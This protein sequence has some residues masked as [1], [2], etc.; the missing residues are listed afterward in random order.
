MKVFFTSYEAFGEGRR[1]SDLYVPMNEL[2]SERLAGRSYGPALDGDGWF[3]M[4]IFQR[5]D[6]PRSRDPERTLY[7]RK[8]AGID[9]R[10]Q[11]DCAAWRA[12]DVDERRRLLYDVIRRTFDI[13]RLKKVPNLDVDAFERDVEAVAL[14]QGWA[15]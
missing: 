7:Q 1:S 12:A 10:L 14:E 5:E 3:L 8:A 4:F 6:G 13:L 2:L 11:A 9:F 15:R